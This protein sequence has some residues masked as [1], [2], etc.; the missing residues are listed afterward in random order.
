[1]GYYLTHHPK[2]VEKI[3]KIEA[4][5]F[6]QA[7]ASPQKRAFVLASRAV[8]PITQVCAWEGNTLM[9][10]DSKELTPAEAAAIKK[11]KMERKTTTKG[12]GEDRTVDVIETM[13]IEM[14][15]GIAAEELIARE[16]GEI[17]REPQAPVNV[18]ILVIHSH[19]GP[20][21]GG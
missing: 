6:A 20:S 21:N 4:D 7:G 11:V 1:M 13:S 14:Y 18:P 3:K 15:D 5:L 8:I 16:S 19:A 2:V 10:K 17:P 9:I 12:K